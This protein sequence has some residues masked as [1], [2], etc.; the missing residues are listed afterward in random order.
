[1]PGLSLPG[2]AFLYCYGWLLFLRVVSHPL[3]PDCTCLVFVL[4]YFF[5][6]CLVSI[7]LYSSCRRDG[8][9][10]LWAILL[11]FIL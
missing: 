5:L 2:E 6:T 3:I 1:M 11:L 8:T 10:V 7:D 4:L 9:G